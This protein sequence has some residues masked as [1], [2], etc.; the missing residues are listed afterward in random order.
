MSI[1]ICLTVRLLNLG[2]FYESLRPWLAARTQ[3]RIGCVWMRHSLQSAP[4]GSFLFCMVSCVCFLPLTHA[5]HTPILSF[6]GQWMSEEGTGQGQVPDAGGLCHSCGI[7]SETPIPSLIWTPFIL[8]FLLL[9]S[10]NQV[11]DFLLF[12]VDHPAKALL[13]QPLHPTSFYIH[14]NLPQRPSSLCPPW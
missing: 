13:A 5:L 10:L 14:S 1:C 2:K 12:S 9:L 3:P 7:V 6:P 11:W 4:S 8:P